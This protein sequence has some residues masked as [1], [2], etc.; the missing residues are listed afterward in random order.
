MKAVAKKE[1]CLNAAKVALNYRDF[2]S[3]LKG[4]GCSLATLKEAWASRKTT[5]PKKS[6][7]KKTTAKKTKR[8]NVQ[9]KANLTPIIYE[10]YLTPVIYKGDDKFVN[11][12]TKAMKE[13]FKLILTLDLVQ[14][15]SKSEKNK[16]L[17][18]DLEKIKK[19]VTDLLYGYD[20]KDFQFKNDLVSGDHHL[21]VV[22]K[23]NREW[24]G[25]DTTVLKSIRAVFQDPNFYILHG[26]N[27]HLGDDTNLK[28]TVQELKKI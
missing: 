18:A 27:C 4:Q 1:V 28:L 19:V 6:I 5:V 2:R 10:R 23:A 9:S 7:V 8:V 14:K 16:I 12:H 13:S 20:V 3:K 11:Q 24:I 26:K 22:L 17:T 25:N 15:R 21:S